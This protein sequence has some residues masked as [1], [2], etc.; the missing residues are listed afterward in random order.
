MSKQGTPVHVEQVEN[1]ASQD[2][3]GRVRHH[4][5]LG[6]FHQTHSCGCGILADIRDISATGIGL[7]VRRRFDPGSVL[8]VELVC[9]FDAS[10]HLI[11]LTVVHATEADNGHWLLG[12]NFPRTLSQAELADLV[13]DKPVG[14][15]FA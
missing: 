14:R 10:T 3:R 1:A 11:P 8:L 15:I 13:L 7:T 4:C 12:C 5:R 6:S 2:S 9:S